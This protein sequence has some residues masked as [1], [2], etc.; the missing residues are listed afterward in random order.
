MASI[1]RSV[2]LTPKTARVASKMGNFS[3]FVRECLERYEAARG[4]GTHA[5]PEG[6]RLAG[7]CNG[8]LR[9]ACVLCYPLG[10]PRREDWLIFATAQRRD[11]DDPRS[12]ANA[13]AYDAAWLLE[14]AAEK[15]RADGDRWEFISESVAYRPPESPQL[16]HVRPWLRKWF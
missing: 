8:V 13:A 2:S 10:G 16:G 9:P 15:A 6:S 14:R 1:I 7:L 3:A 12:E 5:Q 11:D 4:G